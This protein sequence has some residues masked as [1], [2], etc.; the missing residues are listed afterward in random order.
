MITRSR[1]DDAARFRAYADQL[2]AEAV[3]ADNEHDRQQ[4]LQQAR[5]F[6]QEAERLTKGEPHV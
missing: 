1:A 2:R 6:D 4:L 3:D 5:S